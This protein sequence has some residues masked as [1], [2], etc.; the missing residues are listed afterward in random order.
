MHDR[1]ALLTFGWRLYLRLATT[2]VVTSWASVFIALFALGSRLICS[3]TLG[4]AMGATRTASKGRPRQLAM[5]L[6]SFCARQWAFDLGRRDSVPTR[7]LTLRWPS[8]T[9]NASLR[10]TQSAPHDKR[11][12]EFQWG[13]L[14]GRIRWCPGLYPMYRSLGPRICPGTA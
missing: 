11:A 1:T 6:W 9:P 5:R 13:G 8:F 7:L 2:A 14:T 10:K 12:K 3:S 4:P